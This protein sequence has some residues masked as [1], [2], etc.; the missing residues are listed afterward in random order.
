MA[1]I[2][3]MRGNYYSR[4]RWYD[5]INKRVEK[6][7]PLKTNK[8][9]EAVVRNNAVEKLEDLIKLGENCSFLG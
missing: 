9:S 7:I 6:L 3:K 4:V 2:R 8:K 1:S 5:S